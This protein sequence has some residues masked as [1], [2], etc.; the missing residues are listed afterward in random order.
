MTDLDQADPLA[1]AATKAGSAI[2]TAMGAGRMAFELARKTQLS[3]SQREDR[4][5][6]VHQ[7]A[8]T[9]SDEW[10]ERVRAYNPQLVDDYDAARRRG[11]TDEQ[12][13]VHAANEQ[14]K[15][16]TSSPTKTGDDYI[17]R[18]VDADRIARNSRNYERATDKAD[19]AYK[20]THARASAT[21]MSAKDADQA[22]QDAWI[23]RWERDHKKTANADNP[24]Q[25]ANARTAQGTA[26][27]VTAPP[28][29][30]AATKGLRR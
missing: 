10:K 8:T 25:A 3:R 16:T 21:G 20:R 30:Q 19:E 28:Q 1:E 6:A 27:Q 26:T 5:H 13:R 12:A 11:L 17:G 7:W 4:R 24:G 15:R 29:T 22:A 18:S 23:N 14:D 9:G 2:T